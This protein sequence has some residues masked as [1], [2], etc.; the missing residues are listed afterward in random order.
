M[1]LKRWQGEKKPSQEHIEKVFQRENLEFYPERHPSEEKVKEHDHPFD[2]VRMVCSGALLMNV[3]G[4]QLLLRPGDRIEIPSNTRHSH[5]TH[6]NEE[7]LCICAQR[8]F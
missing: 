2:E 7:C 3:A 8:P 5:S 6:G 4:N 1:L